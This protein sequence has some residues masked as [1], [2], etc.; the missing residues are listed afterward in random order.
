MVDVRKYLP[1]SLESYTAKKLKKIQSDVSL[2]RKG[3]KD[4]K[5]DIEH[6][7]FK[8]K[9]IQRKGNVTKIAEDM[10]MPKSTVYSILKKHDIK[11]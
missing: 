7:L 1:F 8:Y 4:I 10:D 11:L 6:A 9:Y 2:Q 3:Y 5:N